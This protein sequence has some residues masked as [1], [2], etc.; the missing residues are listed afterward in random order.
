VDV[1][2]D[3]SDDADLMRAVADSDMAA[4]GELVRRHEKRA[5]ALAC[6]LLTR[7]DAA[8]DVTQE[9]FLHV[10]R[11]AR[12]YR[13]EARFTTWLYR[14]V[15]NLCLD[16]KRRTKRAPGELPAHGPAAEAPTDCDRLEAADR[17]QRVRRAVDDLPGRQRTAVVLH[18]YMQLSH[19]DIA[20]VTGWSV[21]AVESCLVRAYARLRQELRDLMEN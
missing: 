10:Y 5:F 15:V 12:R 18:R 3:A 20:E 2:A 11:A 16:V 13:P 14:I 8:E 19:R 17:A 9:A 21:S 6:R 7:P 1:S 4:L